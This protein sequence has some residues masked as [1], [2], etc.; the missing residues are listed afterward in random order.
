MTVLAFLLLY[1][2]GIA[3][4]WIVLRTE[5]LREDVRFQFGAVTF[6]LAAGVLLNAALGR[7]I[8]T[9]FAVLPA[10]LLW[11]ASFAYFFASWFMKIRMWGL[12][13]A[14]LKV[15]PTFDQAEAAE[16]RQDYALALRMYQQAALQNPTHA[17]TRRRLGEAFL[18]AGDEEQGIMEL[19]AAMGMVED[20]E[21]KMT[22]AFRVVD[23]LVESRGDAFNAEMILSSLEKDYAGTRVADLARARR[24]KL[25]TT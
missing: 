3:T 24:Q 20:P 5:H 1:G 21:K 2:G 9:V 6:C 15:E 23:L 14:K 18:K 10:G 11:G 22:V 4:A 12:G 8:H 16:R 19:R 17:E 13:D 25:R 7:G